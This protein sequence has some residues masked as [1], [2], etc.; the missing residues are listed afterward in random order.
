M[1]QGDVERRRGWRASI[2]APLVIRRLGA[3]EPGPLKEELTE[4]ISLAGVYFETEKGNTYT[5]NDVVMA[6]VAVPESQTRQFPFTRLAGRS[7]V[8]RVNELSGESPGGR[9]RFGIALE[10][11]EDVTAL[12][13]IP[14]RG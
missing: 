4:N 6:S 11:G 5:M 1:K 10:F 14:N 7:R 12:T 8:V 3:Q 13:A 2:K 9:K